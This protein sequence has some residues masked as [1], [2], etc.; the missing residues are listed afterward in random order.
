MD[1]GFRVF[2]FRV[3]G[4]GIRVHRFRVEGVGFRVWNERVE[5]YISTRLHIHICIQGDIYRDIYIY[6]YIC[7]RTGTYNLIL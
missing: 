4:L 3:S 7:I 2:C 1:L 5:T 6:V